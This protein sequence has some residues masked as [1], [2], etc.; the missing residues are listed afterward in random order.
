MHSDLDLWPVDQ[1]T[2]STQGESCVKFRVGCKGKAIMGK[3][4]FPKLNPLWLWPFDPKINGAHHQ[5][6]GSLY[7]KFHDDS[8]KGKAVI[9]RKPFSLIY[10]LWA[11]PLDLKIYRA[12]PWLM[13]SLCMKFH[14]DRCKGNAFMQHKPFSVIN[15]LWPWPST[16]WPQNEWSTSSTHGESSFEVSWW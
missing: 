2:S 16:F 9:R 3:K 4:T 1:G 12:H 6:M 10:V 5:L 15:A 11:W 13:G 7:V 8:Y 14:D